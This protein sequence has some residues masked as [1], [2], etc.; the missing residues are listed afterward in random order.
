VLAFDG[1]AVDQ[2]V[3]AHPA[4]LKA[5]RQFAAPGQPVGTLYV[6]AAFPSASQRKVL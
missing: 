6:T 3:K 4:G 2:A 5:I 1:D